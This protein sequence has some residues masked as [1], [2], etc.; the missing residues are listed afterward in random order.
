MVQKQERPKDK[1]ESMTVKHPH[2]AGIDVGSR[3]HWVAVPPGCDGQPVREFGSFTGQLHELS[4]W[5]KSCRV[6]TVAME[7][8]GVYWIPLYDVLE[9]AGFEVL[10]VNAEH[11]QKVPGRK[12]DVKDCQWIQQLHGFGLL[13][14]S[15][16]PPAEFLELRTYMRQRERIIEDAAR[17]VQRMQKALT[18]MNLQLH[19]VVSDL[20]GVTGMAIVRA[21]VAGERDGHKLAEHRDPRCRQ[22][23]ARIAAALQGTFKTEHLF[24]LEQEL[25]AYD[26]QQKMLRA[27]DERLQQKLAELEKSAAAPPDPE[28]PPPQ[29]C[30]PRRHGAPKGNQPRFEIQSPLHHICHDVD[31]TQIPGIA[32]ATALNLIAEVGTDMS[33]WPTE[34]DFTSWLNLAPGT[35]ITGGKR[36]SG[37]R[38]HSRQ[39]AGEAL[40]Q[41]A[42]AVGRTD[43]ALGGFYRR[44]AGR[45]CAAVA[46]VATA[47]KMAVFLYNALKHGKTFMEVGLA[48]YEK[49]HREQQVRRLTRQAAALGCQIVPVPAEPAASGP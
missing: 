15:F 30:P 35:R 38:R 7:S 9:A 19:H 40:R 16:R 3:S 26:H 4:D 13:R 45:K 11:L 25:S 21:I 48:D 47:R 31:V 23:K 14:G 39:R 43:T 6:V 10:L 17:H 22:P 37:R 18:E 29:P 2:A 44:M 1:S 34:K 42:V 27:G 32:P 49:Q 5:L 8:T 33:K 41:A 36:L 20:T 24:V 12:S 46:A 28:G